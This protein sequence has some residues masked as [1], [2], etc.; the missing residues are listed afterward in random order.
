MS[1]RPP[2]DRPLALAFAGPRGPVDALGGLTAADFAIRPAE[3][4]RRAAAGVEAARALAL[5]PTLTA[6][7][8]R[9]VE[10]DAGAL[11]LGPDGLLGRAGDFPLVELAG[12]LLRGRCAVCGFGP[13]AEPEGHC[14]ACGGVVRPDA[15]LPDELVASRDRL[16][17]EFVVGRAEAVV[18]VEVD[19]YPGAELLTRLAATHGKPMYHFRGSLED[20]DAIL[21]AALGAPSDAP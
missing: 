6:I 11:S 9:A 19:S 2:P 14:P 8:G 3:A 1:D 12:S 15:V 17:A 13:L 7:A 5:G 20:L 16:A 18:L 21:P 10:R 4:V